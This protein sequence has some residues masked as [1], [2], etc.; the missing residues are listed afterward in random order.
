MSTKL[1][2]RIAIDL[3][4]GRVRVPNVDFGLDIQKFPGVDVIADLEDGLP[5]KDESVDEFFA[6][7]LL[8]HLSNPIKIMNEIYRCLTPDGVLH[9]EVPT[10]SGLGAFQDPTHKSFWNENSF[11]Y[12]TDLLR[13]HYPNLIKC[14][15]TIEQMKIEWGWKFPLRGVSYAW[16]VLKKQP[17]EEKY[18]R[19]SDEVS[20]P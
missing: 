2:R 4:C 12:Y 3:G 16:G 17:M 1:R 10:T 19:V 14:R 7:E 15:F 20:G 9:F 11:W 18:E 5:F 8:E 6:V 13:G